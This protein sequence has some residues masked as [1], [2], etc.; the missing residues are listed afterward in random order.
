[1]INLY[2]AELIK[3]TQT[4]AG[5]WKILQKEISPEFQNQLISHTTLNPLCG[6][7]VT[8]YAKI[9]DQQFSFLAHQSIGCIL[10]QAASCL[11]HQLFNHQKLTLINQHLDENNFSTNDPFLSDSWKIFEPVLSAKSRLK[12]VA[13][14][15][16]GLEQLLLKQ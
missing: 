4:Q 1:M 8:W 11:S 7:Q 15:L 10:C 6:D 9:E 5:E 2:S 12:C 16:M 14:P 13:L 3:L